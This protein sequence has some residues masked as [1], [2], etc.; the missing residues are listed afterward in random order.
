[1]MTTADTMTPQPDH[2]LIHL[3]RYEPGVLVEQTEPDFDHLA[4]FTIQKLL[5]KPH[6]FGN[7]ER[8][9]STFRILMR[10]IP[11]NLTADISPWSVV[12]APEPDREFI[13]TARAEQRAWHARLRSIFFGSPRTQKYFGL[14]GSKTPS[15]PSAGDP[16]ARFV[17]ASP[18]DRTPHE[19]PT[20][21]RRT[22]PT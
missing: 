17:V 3:V 2:L 13:V 18:A 11:D 6:V 10:R 15:G 4:W 22:R 20:R 5:G 16:D 1:M 7:D 9:A 14:R 21:T 8:V 12:T 19:W